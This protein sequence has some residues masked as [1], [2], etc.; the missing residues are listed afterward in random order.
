MTN[1]SANH[2]S[3]SDEPRAPAHSL[4]AEVVLGGHRF[5]TGPLLGE[6]AMGRV[7]LVHDPHSGTI[8]ACKESKLPT[9]S[10]ERSSQLAMLK[11]EAAVLAALQALNHPTLPYFLYADLDREPPAIVFEHIPGETL[12]A[13]VERDG[14]LAEPALRE[15]IRSV[16]SAL[17]AMHRLPPD[18]AREIGEVLGESHP[19]NSLIY[20]DPKPSNIL[21]TDDPRRPY[22]LIDYGTTQTSHFG[23]AQPL[24]RRRSSAAV[25]G[26]PP[27]ADPNYA[28]YRELLPTADVYAF[29]ATLLDLAL[30]GGIP[31]ETTRQVAGYLGDPARFDRRQIWPLVALVDRTP[32]SPEL[33]MVLKR[34]LSLDLAERPQDMREFL[35]WLPM[36]TD[37][38]Y[39][40]DAD[41]QVTFIG[42]PWEGVSVQALDAYADL[43]RVRVAAAPPDRIG[44]ARALNQLAEVTTNE[45]ARQDFSR[46]MGSVLGAITPS[47]EDEPHVFIAALRDERRLFVR[48]EDI[49]K[50]VVRNPDPQA[51]ARAMN[52]KELSGSSEFWD[53]LKEALTTPDPIRRRKVARTISASRRALEAS[54]EP[55]IQQA[56]DNELERRHVERTDGLYLPQAAIGSQ[57]PLYPLKAEEI[58]SLPDPDERA[59][60]R[61]M[62]EV[63]IQ[64]AYEALMNETI[65]LDYQEEVPDL[66]VPLVDRRREALFAIAPELQPLTRELYFRAIEHGGRLITSPVVLAWIRTDLERTRTIDLPPDSPDRRRRYLQ[67]IHLVRTAINTITKYGDERLN[68]RGLR[69]RPEDLPAV[70]GELTQ[71]I[72]QTIAADRE[73]SALEGSY[74]EFEHYFLRAMVGGWSEPT[75]LKRGS[76]FQKLTG[77]LVANLVDDPQL[78]DKEDLV[79]PYV[80]ARC[81]LLTEEIAGLRPPD[82]LGIHE[83]LAE[84]HLFARANLSRE[85]RR[86][87]TL[88]LEAFTT[89]RETL[90]EAG[91][92]AEAELMSQ[93]TAAI[94]RNQT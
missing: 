50:A 30:P 85:T 49:L 32:L 33:R 87:L 75:C 55:G 1:E 51:L 2:G 94:T 35:Q 59:Y 71:L 9:D 83:L 23:P 46:V 63:A 73:F 29:A 8:A 20:L 13:N 68:E 6:G 45:P 80:V 21:K 17:A 12:E 69:L 70:I 3:E 26:T 62:A 36:V 77:A 16:G 56:L 47:V 18:L 60:H 67:A 76:A 4:S 40:I 61:I 89:F 31:V 64:D 66:S 91:R 54:S 34:S 19:L 78:A 15:V 22:R 53:P 43:I 93:Y 42:Q 39:Q 57:Q 41:G 92:D 74:P 90:A 88:H 14:P 58:E 65:S 84:L 79:A 25:Y 5:Q 81:R 27:Y 11:Q 86:S 38:D 82:D 7:F 10:A 52:L 48:P 44:L 37:P 72:P 24:E 28:W